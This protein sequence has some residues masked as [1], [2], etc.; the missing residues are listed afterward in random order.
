MSLSLSLL[1]RARARYT[2]NYR[3][4]QRIARRSSDC[5]S[6]VCRSGL[7]LQAVFVAV[8]WSLVSK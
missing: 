6:I 7:Y 5:Q 1:A 3:Y 4:S 2:D 8:A